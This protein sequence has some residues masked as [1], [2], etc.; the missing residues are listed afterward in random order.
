MKF[1]EHRVADRR[2]LRLIQKWLKAGVSE[3]GQWSETKLGTP[4]GA[5]ASPLLANVYL[6]YVFDLWVAVW[7]KKVAKGDA[8]VVRYADDR[9]VGFQHRADAGRLLRDFGERL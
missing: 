1:I 3:D 9:G 6:H 2:I 8:I 5:V 4:Q 7:R